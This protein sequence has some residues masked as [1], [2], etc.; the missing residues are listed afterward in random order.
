MEV[1]GVVPW[2][3]NM[4][5]IFGVSS[6]LYNDLLSDIYLTSFSLYGGEKSSTFLSLSALSDLSFLIF[7]INGLLDILYLIFVN[8]R[9]FLYSYS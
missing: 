9:I 8:K 2:S 3:L 4:L 6:T 1:F 5:Y 7:V